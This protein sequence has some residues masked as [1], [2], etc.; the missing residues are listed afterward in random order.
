MPATD[1][2]TK[3]LRQLARELGVNESTVRR[4]LAK[5]VPV[6]Q[7][8]VRPKKM[9]PQY[10]WQC[11]DITESYCWEWKLKTKRGYG[12]YSPGIPTPHGTTIQAHRA[13]Y[14]IAVGPIPVGYEIDHL[15][16]NPACVRPEHLEAVPPV[17]NT[18]RR[19]SEGRDERLDHCANGH[20]M[21]EENSYHA[22]GATRP[23]CRECN[24]TA[25][26]RYARGGR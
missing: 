24:R 3:S 4:R 18:R 19:H 21:N 8:D 7:P 1:E 20:P 12:L 6:D 26:R 9:T 13:A 25:A 15:C 5:G 23:V 14:M 10:F 16:F 2:S 11:V 17:V 22:P